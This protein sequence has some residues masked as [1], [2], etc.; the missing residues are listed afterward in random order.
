MPGT[1]IVI[2]KLAADYLD[3]SGRCATLPAPKSALQPRQPVAQHA[4]SRRWQLWLGNAASGGP[5]STT[6]GVSLAAAAARAAAVAA[7]GLRSGLHLAARATQ[8]SF[9]QRRQQQQQ[10]QLQ[11]STAKAV[12]AGALCL[13][14][15]RG[16]WYLLATQKMGWC[17]FGCAV[18][19]WP[20]LVCAD[21]SCVPCLCV[22][23]SN[24]SI[25]CSVVA[26]HQYTH[27]PATGCLLCCS[28]GPVGC[29]PKPSCT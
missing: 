2:S 18:E 4:I 20:R 9:R 28:F 21:A 8:L 11:A 7:A 29:P 14:T 6:A 24:A 10:Q 16:K 13:F 25:P 12:D 23:I 5:V 17:V 26:P 19:A 3:S 1:G 15:F 22:P 27:E